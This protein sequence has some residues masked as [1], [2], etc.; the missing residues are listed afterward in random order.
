MVLPGCHLWSGTAALLY[1][2]ASKQHLSSQGNVPSTGLQKCHIHPM[3]DVTLIPREQ[4]RLPVPNSLLA[5]HMTLDQAATLR[6]ILVN[7]GLKSPWRRR[8][9]P[10]RPQLSPRDPTLRSVAS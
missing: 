6:R 7:A 2:A 10:C 5:E 1:L 3:E 8:P 9:L 4:T